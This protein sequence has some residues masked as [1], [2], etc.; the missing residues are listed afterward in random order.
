VSVLMDGKGVQ[1]LE[2]YLPQLEKEYAFW[3]DGADRL[4][5]D[6]NA[7]RR[8]V[9]LFNGTVLNRYWDDKE[10][11]RPEAYTEDLH[12]ASLASHDKEKIY[13]HIRAA[14]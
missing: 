3:M 4:D 8:V 13:K 5:A 14:A 11:P 9:R 10:G 12:I 2:Q 1:V 6:N 7:H